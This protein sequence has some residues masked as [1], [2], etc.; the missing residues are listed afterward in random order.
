MGKAMDVY[1]IL[2]G[3]ILVLGRWMPQTGPERKC[4]IA[5][6]ALLHLL[7]CGL[8]HPHLTGDLMKYHWDF[9][10]AGFASWVP[11]GK[12]PGFFLLMKAVYHLTDGNFQIFLFLIATL[13]QLT[14]ALVIYRYSPAPW[15]G[16]LTL[17]CLGFYLFGFSAIKQALGMALVM[18]AFLGIMEDRP[19]F[20]LAMTL[21]AGA[22]HLP[23]LSFLPAYLLTRFRVNRG[24][25]FAYALAAVALY[26]FRQPVAEFAK[27]LYYG[28]ETTFSWSGGLGGRFFLI[29]LIGTA[30]AMLRGLEDLQFHKLIHLMAVSAILQMFSGFDNVFTR[31]ADVYF[32]FSVIFIPRMLC[33]PGKGPLAFNSRSRRWLTG[34][35]AVCLLIFYWKTNLNVEIVSSVDNYLNFRFFWQER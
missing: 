13:I 12:N 17:N 2:L 3:L 28:A 1:L 14:A 7:L 34:I 21:L 20:F 6:M 16:Y 15:L 23:M 31:L 11:D 29:V 30:G 25:L 4:Y 9:L 18:A 8:R 24:M 10:A 35:A 32:Q 5:L 27:G 26:L 19:K 22:V 33:L